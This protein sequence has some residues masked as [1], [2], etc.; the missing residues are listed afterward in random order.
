MSRTAL[1]IL[2][3]PEFKSASR[4]DRFRLCLLDQA[5]EPLLTNQ[6]YEQWQRIQ[7]VFALCFKQYDQTK[8]IRVIR[9]QVPG[10]DHYATAKRLYDD[11]CEI[12]GPLQRR[13]KEMARS[14]LVQRLWSLGVRLEQRG[15]LVE[16]GEMFEKA[17]K[18][19]G[20]DKHDE[21]DFDP[22]DIELPAITIS[23]DPRFINAEEVEYDDC[24][25]EE[26]ENGEG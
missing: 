23:N 12:Y 26:D 20:L 19:E 16:A 6:E 13:N 7:M 8:A 1:K 3:E 15:D 5:L 11:M 25:E 24:P 14:I 9:N 22:A 4:L 18:F 10:A 17:G 21:A 2:E